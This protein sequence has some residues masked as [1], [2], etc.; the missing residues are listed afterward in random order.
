[1]ILLFAE[2]PE[3][4]PTE[5]NIHFWSYFAEIEV[6][7]VIPLTVLDAADCVKFAPKSPSPQQETVPEEPPHITA[8]VPDSPVD[9]EVALGTEED[10][11]GLILDTTTG[12]F[13]TLFVKLVLPKLPFSLSPQQLTL[14]SAITAQV[15]LLPAEMDMALS[16]SLT[17][18][19]VV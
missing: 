16:M 1:M 14:P 8:H 2:Q 18:T 17:E 7:E 12:V 3:V 9:T 15:C 13:D 11:V 5:S 19:G 10:P 4:E 6:A